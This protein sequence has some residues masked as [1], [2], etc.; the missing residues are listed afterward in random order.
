MSRQVRRYLPQKQR[1]TVELLEPQAGGGAGQR[2]DVRP[3]NFVLVHLPTGT[4]CARA[5][6]LRFPL[7]CHVV[8]PTPLDWTVAAP[9]L[10]LARLVAQG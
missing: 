9:A 7:R 1:Y 6:R 5:R 8:P 10:K 4:R 2:M 3:A